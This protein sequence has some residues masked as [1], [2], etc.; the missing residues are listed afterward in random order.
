[1]RVFGERGIAASSLRD[2]AKAA[3]VSAGLIVHHFGGRE[4]LIAATDEAA[5]REFGEAYYREGEGLPTEGPGLLRARAEQTAR[6]M[7]ERRDVCVYLG[8]ALVEAT[9]GSARLFRLMIEGGRA[10]V[11]ALVER[12]ALREDTDLLWATLQHFFLIWA[13]LSFTALLDQEVLEGSLLDE[14]N[15]Q[16]WVEANVRLLKEGI[17]R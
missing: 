6:V 8:R 10:E 4:G 7:R 16:R 12:G 13:P 11:G 14:P 1:M 2:V 15:L 17:Y 5:L 3:G 9:P